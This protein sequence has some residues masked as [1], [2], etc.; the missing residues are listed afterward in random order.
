MKY[1]TLGNTGM[2][3]SVL[4][5]GAS[6]LGGVFHEVNLWITHRARFDRAIC[7]FPNWTRPETGVIKGMIEV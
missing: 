4:S 5:F 7:E 3:V 2:D 6:S 1:R